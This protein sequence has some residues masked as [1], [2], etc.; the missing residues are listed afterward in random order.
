M[1]AFFSLGREAKHFL[2]RSG[3]SLFFTSRYGI[4][5]HAHT[6]ARMHACAHACMCAC[7]HACTTDRPDMVFIRTYACTHVRMHTCMLACAHAHTHLCMHACTHDRRYAQPT[8]R[9][10]DRPLLRQLNEMG[11]SSQNFPKKLFQ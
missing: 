8:D 4:Y 7:M 3:G 1:G 5:T 9:P 10:T 11:V 2:H 6:Y